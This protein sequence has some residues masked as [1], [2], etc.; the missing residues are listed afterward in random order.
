M[1]DRKL[2]LLA[3]AAVIVA[4]GAILQSR[5]A[6]R[7]GAS[8]MFQSS[9]LIQGLA[10]DA[11]ARIT[12]TSE[13]GEKT[14]TLEK[15][16][17]QFVVVDKNGYPANVSAVNTLLNNCLDIRTTEHITS[18]AANHADLGITDQTAR[19]GVRFFN[20]EGKEITGVLISEMQSN[21][22]GAFAR[23][24]TSNEA[25][26]IQSPPWLS[27]GPIDYIDST[28]I[29]ADR[30]KMRKVIVKG[31][32]GEYVLTSADGSDVVVLEPMPEGKQFKGTTYRSVFGALSGLRCEDVMSDEKAPEGLAYNQSY[33]CQME[34]TTVYTVMLGKL[35]EKTYVTL[36]AEFLDK[37]PV[38]KERRV[39]SEEELKKK[40]AKLLAID[41]VEAFN[42]R[43]KGWVY[44][45]PSYKATELTKKMEELLEDKPAPT[46]D[47]AEP[48]ASSAEDMNEQ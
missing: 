26:F 19:Y 14:T 6:H 24:T 11:I 12:I 8:A 48:E 29:Q 46:E 39:E 36:S 20:A 31:P 47:N 28:L 43:H 4:G 27:T 23:L 13:K 30:A 37:T 44:Q 42:Q 18:D 34:D 38:E 7:A 1:T 3:I 45:I 32:S 5:L 21:P 25:Y 35:D 2:S 41:A 22:D 10:L 33:V 17:K 9:P 15:K 16:D 40:E